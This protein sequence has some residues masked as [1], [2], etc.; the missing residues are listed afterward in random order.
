MVEL[1]GKALEFWRELR[2]ASIW[3]FLNFEWQIRTGEH[4]SFESG[5]QIACYQR[6]SDSF[7]GQL[8]V[9]LTLKLEFDFF[10]SNFDR[11]KHEACASF[12]FYIVKPNRL[13]LTNVF[14]NPKF[15]F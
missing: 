8:S 4:A 5:E 15:G 7:F 10:V 14:W 6:K 2:T 13:C 9:F 11:T 12:K 3:I 1:F